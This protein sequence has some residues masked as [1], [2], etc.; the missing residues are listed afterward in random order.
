MVRL[1]AVQYR[2]PWVRFLS[3]Q[4]MQPVGADGAD[5]GS[6][7]SSGWVCYTGLAITSSWHGATFNI[8][9][10][11]CAVHLA[12]T[13]FLRVAYVLSAEAQDR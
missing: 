11:Y 2:G 7:T 3:G 10:V 12:V 1:P 6:R 5:G 13:L 9:T 4:V 8:M